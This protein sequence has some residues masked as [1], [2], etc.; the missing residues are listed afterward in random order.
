ML[1]KVKE[2]KVIKLIQFKS[3]QWGKRHKAMQAQQ[4]Q[5]IHKLKT[6]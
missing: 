2:K 3:N 4:I 1:Q 6:L 5:V